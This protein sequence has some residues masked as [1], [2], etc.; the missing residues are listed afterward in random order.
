MSTEVGTYLELTH[1]GY[2]LIEQ[3][4]I[5]INKAAIFALNNRQWLNAPTP[6]HTKIYVLHPMLTD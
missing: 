2:F 4:G 1:L 6:D 3:V 5:Y